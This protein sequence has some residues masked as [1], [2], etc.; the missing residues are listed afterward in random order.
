M[1]KTD[2]EMTDYGI[3]NEEIRRTKNQQWQLAFYVVLLHAAL[4]IFHYFVNESKISKDNNWV[5]AR[6]DEASILFS[7]A[8]LILGVLLILFYEYKMWE[9]RGLCEKIRKSEYDFEDTKTIKKNKII[10]GLITIIMY[11]IFVSSGAGSA[12]L[13]IMFIIYCK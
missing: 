5:V 4:I 12:Y 6:F 13:A 2:L 11:L 10:D 3:Y 8:I 1:E 7:I 9:Y